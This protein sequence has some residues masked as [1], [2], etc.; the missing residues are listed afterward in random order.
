MA[1]KAQAVWAIDLGSATLKA[2]KLQVGDGGNLEVVDFDIIEHSKIL[3]GEGV[4]ED[5]AN[6]LMAESLKKFTDTHDVGNTDV[7]L[8]V[9]G[10]A[11]FVRFIKLPPVEAK[12]LPK[13]VQFEAVQQIPFDINEVEWDYQLMPDT[14]EPETSVGIFAIKNEIIASIL[15]KYA[16]LNMNV[17][18]VQTSPMALYNYAHYEFKGFGGSDRKATVILDIGTNNTH[19]VI[20][21]ANRVWQRSFQMGGNDFTE[22]IEDTFNVSF[23]KAE[24]LKRNAPASK[25]SRQLFQAMK[26]VFARLGE[27]IQR[28]ISYYSGSNNVEYAGMICMGGGMKLQGLT[29]YLQQSLGMSVIRPDTF[30]RA[31]PAADVSLPKL[32]EAVP[33]LGVVYGLA[34]QGL[35]LSTIQSNLLPR[36]MARSMAWQ[37]KSKFITA[38]ASIVLIA[39][40]LC[41]G[42]ALKDKAAYAMNEDIRRQIKTVQS[43]ANEASSTLSE[44]E[45]M[46]DEYS[47]LIEEQLKVFE[48]RTAILRVMDIIVACMPNPQNN[49]EQAQLYESFEQGDVA[50]I[51]EIPRDQRK[52]FFVTTFDVKYAQSLASTAFGETK[53]REVG[54][55]STGG[56]GD[57]GMGMEMG[58]PGMGMEMGMPGMGMPG[59]DMGGFGMPG[60]EGGGMEDEFDQDDGPGFV[61][62]IE[63]YT[64]YGDIAELMDPL[65]VGDDKSKWGFVTRLVNIDKLFEDA[66]LE[67]F[68]K[69]SVSHFSY[70]TGIVDLEDRNMPAGIGEKKVITRVETSDEENQSR[71]SGTYKS[72][73]QV[74]A[75]EV[76]VDPMTGEEISKTYDLGP[77]GE[78]RFDN[79]G[80]EKFIVRDHWF[81]IKAK[82]LWKDALNTED[83][84]ED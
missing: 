83:S 38:A 43:Q 34:V 47:R 59:G 66:G 67:I 69:E 18:C 52:L 64:P 5:E 29:R 27:E 21:S 40:L 51:T 48:D 78:I 49:P 46:Q 4:S 74:F 16:E 31:K 72:R 71:R 81:R 75:E 54:G 79:N 26:P 50:A 84:D 32:N 36:R 63:G 62:V 8:A 68:R 60:Y 23:E 82:F 39:T 37:Q 11:S 3:S 13:V 55:T 76:L 7:S 12:T 41:L 24:K 33:D 77:N 57:M 70:E 44:A 1:S 22:A 28:S 80:E 61:V 25:H 17:T 35:D 65:G 58:M 9:A 45:N 56:M 42:R 20:C 53:V 14:S 6:K 73:N 30:R 19:L 15:R 2:L 10:Q